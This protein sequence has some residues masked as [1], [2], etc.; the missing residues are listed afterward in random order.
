MQK[1]RNK[2]DVVEYLCDYLPEKVIVKHEGFKVPFKLAIEKNGGKGLS[3]VYR[4][5]SDFLLTEDVVSIE[6]TD[7]RTDGGFWWGIRRKFNAPMECIYYC[8]YIRSSAD[9]EIALKRCYRFLRKYKLIGRREQNTRNKFKWIQPID[10]D[11]I[12]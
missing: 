9:L 8:E 3:L 1:K 12:K 10:G 2:L 11:S 6:E 7:N 5:Y 4:Y